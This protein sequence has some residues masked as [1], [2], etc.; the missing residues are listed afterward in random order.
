MAVIAYK[1]KILYNCNS[2][3]FFMNSAKTVVRQKVK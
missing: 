2:L 3:E 1:P